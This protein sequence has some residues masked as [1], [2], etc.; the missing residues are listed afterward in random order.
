M[1]DSLTIVQRREI[2]QILC[3]EILIATDRGS[4]ARSISLTAERQKPWRNI[5]TKPTFPQA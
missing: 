3:P 5:P 1:S 2:R 4:Q